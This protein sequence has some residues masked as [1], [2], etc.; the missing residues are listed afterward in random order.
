MWDY[1]ENAIDIDYSVVKKFSMLGLSP[2]ASQD[3]LDRATS[4]LRALRDAMN[5]T[6]KM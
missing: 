1:D 6:G 2:P 3:D 5:V 4:E